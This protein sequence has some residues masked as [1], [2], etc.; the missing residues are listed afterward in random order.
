MDGTAASSDYEEVAVVS[1]S[2]EHGSAMLG[3]VLQAPQR[4]AAS[5]GCDSVIHVRYERGM[6][7]ASATGVAVRTR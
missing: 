4:E 6:Y 1:A 3:A 7:I 5:L 2:G